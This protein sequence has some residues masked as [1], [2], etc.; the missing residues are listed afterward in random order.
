MVHAI[1]YLYFAVSY[2]RPSLVYTSPILPLVVVCCSLYVAV[3]LSNNYSCDI[4]SVMWSWEN[5]PMH[6]IMILLGNTM[7]VTCMY[8]I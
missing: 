4:T 1:S 5:E 2:I 8:C 7:L 6:I 3:L